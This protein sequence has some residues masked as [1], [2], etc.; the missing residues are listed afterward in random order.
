M[1]L[2]D[3]P[4][5]GDPRRPSDHDKKILPV[6]QVMLGHSPVPIKQEYYAH[7]SPH[8]TVRGAFE[9]GGFKV[10]QFRNWSAFQDV[11]TFPVHFAILVK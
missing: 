6:I 7:F 1:K 9:V 11:L 10:L 3:W 2:S 8:H 5:S 4:L